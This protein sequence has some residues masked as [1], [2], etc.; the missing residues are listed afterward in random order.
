MQ[1]GQLKRR[2]FLALL[3]GA[4]AAWPFAARA[5]QQAD[6]AGDRRAE[7]HRIYRF[8]RSPSAVEN[9]TIPGNLA[10]MLG[11]SNGSDIRSWRRGFEER[12]DSDRV[13]IR[14][15]MADVSVPGGANQ[16]LL[17]Q[18]MTGDSTISF[19]YDQNGVLHRTFEIFIH[20]PRLA[21]GHFRAV[22]IFDGSY[23]DL[24]K[25]VWQVLIKNI[26]P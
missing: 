6:P 16:L 15:Y 10:K 23:N 18:V 20:Q 5:Q 25:D 7:F 1:I 22:E 14:G 3:C 24:G 13:T 2:D 11:W 26:P 12:R 9:Q 4:A 17:S 19:L 8:A 21:S